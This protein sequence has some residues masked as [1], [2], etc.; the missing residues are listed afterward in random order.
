MLVN[1]W[2]KKL[3]TKEKYSYHT[4]RIL[5]KMADLIGKIGITIIGAIMGV[6]YGLLFG[7]TSLIGGCVAALLG[8]LGFWGLVE[9]EEEK[10]RKE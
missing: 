2:R 10:R 9:S 5:N 1:I 7:V 6:L 8:A 4:R 3:E